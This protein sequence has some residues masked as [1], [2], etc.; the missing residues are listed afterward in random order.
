MTNVGCDILLK[1]RIDTVRLG[2]L[3]LKSYIIK[4]RAWDF[5][6]ICGDVDTSFVL[7]IS[8]PNNITDEESIQNLIIYPNPVSNDKIIIKVDNNWEI[9]TI[10]FININGVVVKETYFMNLQNEFSLSDL[11]AGMYIVKIYGQNSVIVRKLI[12]K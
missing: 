2:K 10:Q 11:E 6:K 4:Y 9:K 3:S 12:K 7:K 1:N 8:E 5:G